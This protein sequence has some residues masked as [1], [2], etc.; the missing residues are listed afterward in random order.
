MNR[1]H[2]KLLSFL[3]VLVLHMILLPPQQ[4]TEAAV[5]WNKSWKYRRK[6]SVILATQRWS[7]AKAVWVKFHCSGAIRK[8][9]RDLRATDKRG[10]QLKCAVKGIGPGDEVLAVFEAVKGESEYYLYYGNSLAKPSPVFD[11]KA[12]LILETRKRGTGNPNSW[13]D[14]QRIIKSSTYIY[15]RSFWDKIYSGHNPFGPVEDFISIFS[16]YILAPKAGKYTFCT[17]SDD[18]SFMFIDNKLV[19]QWPGYHSA[20]A[21]LWGRFSGTIY[22]DKGLHPIRYYHLQAADQS[23]CVAGWKQPG[24]DNKDVSLI[25]DW[26]FPGLLKGRAKMQEKVSSSVSCDFTFSV[27]RELI[28]NDYEYQMVRF[29][30]LVSG[31]DKK[32]SFRDGGISHERNPTHVFLAPGLFTVKFEVRE[33]NTVKASVH[34]EIQA[35]YAPKPGDKTQVLARRLREFQ[36]FVKGY[37]IQKLLPRLFAPLWSF[38]WETENKKGLAL[39]APEILERLDDMPAERASDIAEKVGDYFLNDLKKPKEALTAFGVLVRQSGKTVKAK[40]LIKSG[41]VYLFTLEDS[42]KARVF[43]EKVLELFGT[44]KSSEARFANIRLGDIERYAGEFDAASGHYAKAEAILLS[45]RLPR[46]LLTLRGAYAQSVESYLIRKQ[47][48]QAAKELDM[49]EWEFPTERL[50]GYSSYLR[51]RMNFGTKK[52]KEVIKEAETVVKV[53]PRSN[54]CDK[55]LLIEADAYVKTGDRASAIKALQR[56]LKDYPASPLVP[57]IRSRISALKG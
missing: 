32:T 34:H 42:E 15:G 23:A 7:D 29:R 40:G 36:P 27:S 10:R 57:E 20:G 56:I 11:P 18:A 9:G 52:Y 26:A 4:E 16:G 22:L 38:Y 31:S 13:R 12:G 6:V 2:L 24:Q 1:S 54:Y 28:C 45:G 25:P 19:C 8:D 3:L 49:W 55:L 37:D 51:C 33:G 30:G 47:Y 44:L 5:W 41:D 14:M 39:L 21:G 17:A 46:Q 43:Y 50:E 53:N 35:I 48:E